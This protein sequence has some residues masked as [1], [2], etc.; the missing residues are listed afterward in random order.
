[1]QIN[2]MPIG[3]VRG[4]RKEATKDHWGGNRSQIEL[5]SGRFGPKALAGIDQLSHI[6]VLFYFHLHTDEPMEIGA[7][8]PRDRADWP[9]VGIF[10]QRGR[11][12]PNRIGLCACRVIAV[13]GLA[14]EVDG[15]DAVDGTP[16]LD[17]KP[18]W[19][20][21]APRGSLREPAWAKE[22]MANYW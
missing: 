13:N 8:H 20:G 21:N 22:I 11:M 14:I 18:V 5:D 3:F 16:V 4:G 1:M 10:A 19:S 6:E 9:E 17:I 2:M 15:L 12:R 7:R